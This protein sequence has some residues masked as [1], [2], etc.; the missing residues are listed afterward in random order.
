MNESDSIVEHYGTDSLM[1]RINSAL[2][3]A[4]LGE[5]NVGWKDLAPLDQFHVRG[6]PATQELAS[7]MDIA[8]GASILDIGCGVGGAS[9]FL[10]VSYDAHVTGIDLNPA[11]IEAASAL[12]VRAGLSG[13]TTFRVAN[14]LDLP[15]ETSSFDDAWTQH[16]AMN[17]RDRARL[18]SEVF[19]VLK[20]GGQF[21]IHDIVKVGD[22]PLI[23]PVPWARGPDTSFLLS[24]AAMREIL[25]KTGFDIV[26]WSDT[27][28]ATKEWIAHIQAARA[29]M[30]AP[31]PMG[32][33]VVTGV[34]FPTMMANLGRNLDEGRAGLVQTVV[35][36][37]TQ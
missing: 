5:G 3:K 6:L 4:G 31:P 23:F 13:R 36:R 1:P 22:Q 11:F 37:P 20:P 10:A 25:T 17:I 32:L 16:V 34:D 27:T 28:E 24:S 7:S 12:S 19:R 8:L 15:F 2:S 9:R 29:A 26:S 21:A 33:Y 30:P 14:A 35:R 18:Y